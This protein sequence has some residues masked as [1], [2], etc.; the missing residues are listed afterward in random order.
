MQERHFRSKTLESIVQ[1][2]DVTAKIDLK[3]WK[4]K[5]ILWYISVNEIKFTFI[6]FS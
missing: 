3:F 5:N 6:N 4:S 1:T 2:S